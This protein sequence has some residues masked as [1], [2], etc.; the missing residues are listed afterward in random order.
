MN[1]PYVTDYAVQDANKFSKR[2]SFGLTADY[3]LARNDRLSLSFQ[4]AFFDAELSNRMLTFL[5]QRVAPGDFDTTFTH[6]QAGAGLV[7]LNNSGMR[8]KSGTTYTPTF[9]YR[10]DGPIWK[11]EGGL[12]SSRASNH[13]RDEYRGFCNNSQAQR[14]NVTVSFADIFYLRPNTITVTDAAGSPV[15]PYQLSNYSLTSASMGHQESADL[16]RTAYGNLRRDFSLGGIPLSLKGGLEMKQSVR[17][18][19]K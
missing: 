1:K 9:I 12:G 8:Q 13:Y 15:D 16:Q 6:G 19:R 4:W 2:T 18:I 10:H 11:A 7:R 17:D 5:V 3:K 14:N